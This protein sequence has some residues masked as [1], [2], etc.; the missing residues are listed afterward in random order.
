[1]RVGAVLPQR[2]T[3]PVSAGWTALIANRIAGSGAP[4]VS[5]RPDTRPPLPS[6]IDADTSPDVALM[7]V[8]PTSPP[9]PRARTVHVPGSIRLASFGLRASTGTNRGISPA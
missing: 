7:S 4:S 8:M 2:E 5:T 6:V 1:G 3:T 9:F